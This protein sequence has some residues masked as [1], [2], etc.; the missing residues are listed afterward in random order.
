MSVT[1]PRA[2]RETSSRSSTS[3]ARCWTWRMITSS[4]MRCVRVGAQ[5][6]DLRGRQD[7]RERVAQLVRQQRQELVLA[8]IGLEDRRLR[9]LQPGDV[10]ERSDRAARRAA[11]IAQRH[12]AAIQMLHLSVLEA[13]LL[14]VVSDFLSARGPLEWKLAVRNLRAVHENIEVSRCLRIFCRLRQVVARVHA[15]N[16]MAGPVAAQLAASGSCVIHT[17][18]G[19][20]SMSAVSSSARARA[21]ASLARNAASMASCSVTSIPTIRRHGSPPKSIRALESAS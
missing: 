21:S 13:K 7:R 16:L 2:T 19:T 12:R 9:L 20:A 4:S 3:R 5:L 17:A 11:G 14:L 8:T 6:Q 10:H 1:F 15:Q 18:A